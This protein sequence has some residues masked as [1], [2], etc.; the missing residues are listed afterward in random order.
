MT[1][2][3]IGQF[4]VGEEAAATRVLIVDDMPENIKLMSAL[5]KSSGYTIDSA[6]DGEGAIRLAGENPPD[7]VL[8]DYAM[9]GMDGIEVCRALKADPRT[10]FAE[11]IMVT[12]SSDHEIHV[13]ALEA[14]ADDFLHKPIESSILRARVRRSVRTKRLMDANISYQR[15]L[16]DYSEQLEERI[17]ERT[18]QVVRTQHVTVFALAKLSESRDNETGA[19]LERM[20]RY[21]L[22][23]G[24]QM[25]RTEKYRDILTPTFLDMLYFSSPLHD[26]GKVGIPDAIL[27]KPGKLTAEEYDIMKLHTVIGGR[28]LDAAND[29][30][31]SDTFLEMGRDIAYAHHEKWDGSGYPG[32]LS[33][34]D[35]PLPARITA[36]GDVYDALTSRRPYKEPFSHEKSKAIICEGKGT[37]FDPE[38]VDAFLAIESEFVTIAAEHQDI[39]EPSALEQLI[40]QLPVTGQ[41]SST[42]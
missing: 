23:L 30:A 20:S 16:K 39:G 19:H 1:D 9:P 25:A 24:R 27:L 34:T 12:G 29:E 5:L 37:H 40:S 33:G 6:T 41:A 35:I 31:E 14:G 2:S 32:G 21:T 3:Q 28:T 17:L 8:L 18:Q 42:G 38:V 4:P 36:L 7:V 13:R 11:V 10:A 15:E 26:I 22:A